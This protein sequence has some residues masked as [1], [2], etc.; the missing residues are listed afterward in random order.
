MLGGT[1]T[2]YSTCGNLIDPELIIHFHNNL[3]FRKL[4]IGILATGSYSSKQNSTSA[5]TR[6]SNETTITK[7]H[8]T[9][10]MTI[11]QH[12]GISTAEGTT[13]RDNL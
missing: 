11:K 6:M 13:K 10:N 2:T 3:L 9:N 5:A 7:G 12:S 4:K 1:P 8:E